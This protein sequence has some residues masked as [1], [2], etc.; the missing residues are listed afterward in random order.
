MNHR[1]DHMLTEAEGR[2]LTAEESRLMVKY[3]SSLELRLAAMNALEKVEEKIV[4]EVLTVVWQKHP[5]FERAH[6]QAKDRCRRD[7]T[8]V[9]R[10]CATA[11]LRDDDKFLEEKLLH[12]LHTILHSFHFGD[13]IA[14][15]YRALPQRVEANISAQYNQ[16]LAPYLKLTMETLTRAR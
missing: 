5:E 3:A 9:L 1:F 7:V 6:H 4:D 10:Y 14:T 16:L 15:T 2:Y 12:W 11:M 13:V 8:L